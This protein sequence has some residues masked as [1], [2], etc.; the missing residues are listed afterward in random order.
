MSA[1]VAVWLIAKEKKG[2]EKYRERRRRRILINTIYL[3]HFNIVS[4]LSIPENSL[5]NGE[6]FNFS[7]LF[8]LSIFALFESFEKRKKQ[9]PS[10][11]IYQRIFNFLGVGIFAYRPVTL[12]SYKCPSNACHLHHLSKLKMS[13]VMSKSQTRPG[14][15]SNGSVS[16]TGLDV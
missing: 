16:N 9:N 7:L 5:L 13:L 15:T 8:F 2:G 1:L 11:I 3:I 6:T 10:K 12:F 4:N 14:L